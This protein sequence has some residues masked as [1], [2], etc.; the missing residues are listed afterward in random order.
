LYNLIFKSITL[1][2]WQRPLPAP[3]KNSGCTPDREQN[4]RILVGCVIG[5]IAQ[6]GLDGTHAET[7]FHVL[8]K[9]DEFM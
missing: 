2:Q 1:G 5:G 8:A 9:M 4:A 7:I 3:D 6:F